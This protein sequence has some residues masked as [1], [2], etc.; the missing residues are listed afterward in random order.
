MLGSALL[1]FLL[2]SHQTSFGEGKVIAT[3]N[4][5][6]N[7]NSPHWKRSPQEH[8]PHSP[9][10]TPQSQQDGEVRPSFSSSGSFR[11][12]SLYPN[13]SPDISHEVDQQERVKE[14]PRATPQF[15]PDSATEDDERTL[16]E[17]RFPSI[18][19]F[20]EKDAELFELGEDGIL[21]GFDPDDLD[22][23]DERYD[24]VWMVDEWEE[25]FDGD[26]DELMEWADDDVLLNMALENKLSAAKVMG[27]HRLRD[28][29]GS[30][31]NALMDEDEASPFQRLVADSWLF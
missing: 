28:Q 3:Y 9:Y 7:N 20:D 11:K 15:S 25:D 16:I 2:F 19:L 17:P 8:L 30:I 31:Q 14:S 21:L 12:R 26:M 27:S 29:Q 4:S 6:E 10:T 22:T 1:T 24:Q 23:D 5:D 13:V 18:D